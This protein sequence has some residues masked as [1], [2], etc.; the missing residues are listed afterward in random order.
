MRKVMITEAQYDRL[1]K[2]LKESLSSS[3]SSQGKGFRILAQIMADNFSFIPKFEDASRVLQGGN[4]GVGR[5]KEDYDYDMETKR[6]FFIQYN[7]RLY[8]YYPKEKLLY[9]ASRNKVDKTKLSKVEL[10]QISNIIG[11]TLSLKSFK[12]GDMEPDKYANY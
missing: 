10:E 4:F 1:I 8:Q 7:D 6:Y 9:D 12:F 2:T 5:N 11:K 3:G